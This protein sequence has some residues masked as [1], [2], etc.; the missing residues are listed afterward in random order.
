LQLTQHTVTDSNGAFALAAAPGTAVAVVKKAGLATAWKTWNSL[1]DDSSEPVVLTAPT[2]L[3]G[4]VL[5][6]SN[7]PVAGAE[8]WVANA[9]IAGEYEM[10]E[11]ENELFGKAARECFSTKTAADGRFR[12]GN[13]PAGGQASLAVKATGR[14]QRPFGGIYAGERDCRAGDENIELRVAPSGAVEGRVAIEDT[15]QPLAGVKI[16][17]EPAESGLYGAEYCD[18]I[19]SDADGTFRFPDVQPGKYNAMAVIPGQPV[20]GWVVSPGKSENTQVTV[21][22]G[23][24]ARGVVFRASK[25]ALVEVTVVLTNERTPLADAW[26]SS[27]GSSAFTGSNGMALV[28]V[29]LDN[30]K[31]SFSTRKDW[32]TQRR[33]AVIEPGRVNNVLIELVPPPT[34]SGTVRDPSGA[35]VAGALVS[36]HPG[37]YPDAPHYSEVT[38]DKN[39]RYKITLKL[40]RETGLWVGWIIDTN[41]VMARD[42]GRNL[43]A[44][45]GFDKVPA[46][47]DLDLQPGI[48]LS[49][50]VKDTDGAPVTNARVDLRFLLNGSLPQWTPRPATV[51]AQGS[52]SIPAMPQGRDYFIY[53]VIAKGCG[54]GR[55]E[56]K[57]EETK[58][59]HYEF[60]AIVLKQT[61]RKLAGQ[62]LGVDGKPLAGVQ[63]RFTGPGQPQIGWEP[64]AAKSDSRGHF[65][66]D[67]VCEGPVT[68]MANSNNIQAQVPARGGDTN[69]VVNLGL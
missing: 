68:V 60:P 16:K 65:V 18:P 48:T 27:D 14:A 59:N 25:G 41:C 32:L 3:V 2:A 30:G 45:Q 51:N 6:E 11:Q 24:T 63:V 46:N 21:A 10:E 4:I 37:Q 20:P 61:G 56:V 44:L 15:G 31:A 9:I 26:V 5:D 36:F 29:P 69:V 54:T 40:S 50:S 34:I 35:P 49:G 58:T 1:V 38:T 67:A 52:F 13:F 53:Q 7:S 55:A 17:L 8:V 19:E 62:V 23:K 42:P 39:G 22:A 43:V 47:L 33:E 28:R 64:A 66:F 57:A 12:I